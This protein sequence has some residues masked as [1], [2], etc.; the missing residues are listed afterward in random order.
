[1]AIDSLSVGLLVS[2]RILNSV[3]N[4]FTDSL[5]GIDVRLARTVAWRNDFAAFVAPPA[6]SLGCLCKRRVLRA[7][8]GQG[9]LIVCAGAALAVVRGFRQILM[10]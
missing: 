6:A 3:E 7:G 2:D 10:E 4:P 8:P 1:M 5:V 9:P